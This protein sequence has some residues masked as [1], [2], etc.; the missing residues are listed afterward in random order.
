[1]R[2]TIFDKEAQKYI[3]ARIEIATAKDMPFKKDKWKFNWRELYKTKGSL[4][5]KLV[6]DDIIEGVVMFSVK[7]DEM[8]FM[9]NIEIA[10]H[11]YGSNGRYD[12]VAGA[13]I[14]FGCE[15]SLI[16]G[17]RSYEGYLVFDSKEALIPFYER[18][19]GAVYTMGRS[20][21]IGPE[22]G[23]KLI[24]KYLKD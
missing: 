13:L 6:R 19:Y 21:F 22:V 20:I 2:V 5:Y 9:N 12:D 15:L 11:N 4:I 3:E 17:L 16:K 1:M 8:F 10:P 14:A 24:E 7:Y 18:K 23:S